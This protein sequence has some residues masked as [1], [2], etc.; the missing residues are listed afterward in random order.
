MLEKLL[1]IL[2]SGSAYTYREL[3]QTLGISEVMLVEMLK[4]LERLG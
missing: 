3:A 1:R 4:G 2:A